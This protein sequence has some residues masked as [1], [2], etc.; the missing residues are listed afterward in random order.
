MR[1]VAEKLGIVIG[2]LGV[3]LTILASMPDGPG[4][5]TVVLACVVVGLLSV[6]AVSAFVRRARTTEATLPQV[7]SQRILIADIC[8]RGEA[9][10]IAA[11][12]AVRETG[13]VLLA[14]AERT[15]ISLDTFRMELE[16]ELDP[17]RQ[18]I[19]EQFRRWGKLTHSHLPAAFARYLV[20]DIADVLAGPVGGRGL[21]LRTDTWRDGWWRNVPQLVDAMDALTRSFRTDVID[22]L[23]SEDANEDP[24]AAIAA[25]LKACELVVERARSVRYDARVIG[26]S[27]QLGAEEARNS[28]R[29]EALCAPTS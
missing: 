13:G 1:G 11:A 19:L 8:R 3:V 29:Q 15:Y 18:I 17:G 23:N 25:A 9:T 28:I 14:I 10:D 24:A 6:V 21:L 5:P 12:A 7:V 27:A 4:A 26:V 2:L 16:E 20:G 22:P